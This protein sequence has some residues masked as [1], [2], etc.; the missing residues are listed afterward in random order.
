M[1][2]P[3][4]DPRK[5]YQRELEERGPSPLLQNCR[6]APGRHVANKIS[7]PPAQ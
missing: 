1:A 4:K 5:S 3:Y 6:V 2:Y 7:D